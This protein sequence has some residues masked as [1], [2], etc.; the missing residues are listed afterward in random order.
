MSA[1]HPQWGLPRFGWVSSV[2]I[3]LGLGVTGWISIDQFGNC[4]SCGG[5]TRITWPEGFLATMKQIVIPEA[6]LMVPGDRGRYGTR[7][8]RLRVEYL[9][10]VALVLNKRGYFPVLS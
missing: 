4:R 3:S 10:A 5:P 2:E 8:S 9:E 7:G 1:E 6:K